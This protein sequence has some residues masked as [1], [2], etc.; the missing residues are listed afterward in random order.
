MIRNTSSSESNMTMTSVTIN[1]VTYSINNDVQNLPFFK[2]Y[3]A[4]EF[5]Q[6][7]ITT[8]FDVDEKF[9]RG[10]FSDS[11]ITAIDY[12]NNRECVD[13]FGLKKIINYERIYRVTMPSNFHEVLHVIKFYYD[14][15]QSIKNDYRD[16][17]KA[18]IMQYKDDLLK[19]LVNHFKKVS[20]QPYEINYFGLLQAKDYHRIIDIIYNY[21]YQKFMNDF[22][23]LCGK[24]QYQEFNIPEHIKFDDDQVMCSNMPFK[25]FT[26]QSLNVVSI[27]YNLTYDDERNML[28]LN[29]YINTLRNK[30]GKDLY[31]V[32]INHDELQQ[33]QES[34]KD[35]KD[36]DFLK[37]YIFEQDVT[38]VITFLHDDDTFRMFK[39]HRDMIHTKYLECEEDNMCRPKYEDFIF[40]VIAYHEKEHFEQRYDTSRE[41]FIEDDN[42]RYVLHIKQCDNSLFGNR[43]D[44]NLI[45]REYRCYEY[46]L[47][48]YVPRFNFKCSIVDEHGNA[49]D[50]T[51]LFIKFE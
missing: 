3:L 45:K 11:M 49:V 34:D 8:P 48:D 31:L 23:Q 7:N 29:T 50:A 51:K 22:N 5:K 30:Y 33:Y 4:N 19:L 17:V 41:K 12:N 39:F 37:L 32:T 43:E 28:S 36:I 25:Q 47:F 10:V 27:M 26:R 46:W 42:K 24:L 20:Q 6:M 16:E 2:A 44:V 1:D 40:D 18:L 15:S 38:Y 14:N 13:Y 9:L 35:G 21:E